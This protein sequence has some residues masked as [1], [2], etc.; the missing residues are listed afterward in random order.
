MSDKIEL[1]DVNNNDAIAKD[2]V[3]FLKDGDKISEVI[4]TMSTYLNKEDKIWCKNA[5][6]QYI[7]K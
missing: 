4:A 1:K 3:E 7:P 6:S 2:I 5:I